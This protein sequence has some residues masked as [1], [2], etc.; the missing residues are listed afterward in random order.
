MS[1][2]LRLLV[3]IGAATGLSLW[4]ECSGCIGLTGQVV[5]DELAESNTNAIATIVHQMRGAR[6]RKEDEIR[7]ARIRV[8]SLIDYHESIPVRIP[9]GVAVYYY[10]NQGSSRPRP[11]GLRVGERR[12]F[13]CDHYYV[14]GRTNVLI[15]IWI[16]PLG[17]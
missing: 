17:G 10:S 9:D 13:G 4:A 14:A 8:E 7:V 5:A 1:S 16:V 3:L 12:W 11:V 6:I 15:A 2:I